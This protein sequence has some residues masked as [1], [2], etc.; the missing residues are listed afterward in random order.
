MITRLLILYFFA[1]LAALNAQEYEIKSLT[2]NNNGGSNSIKNKIIFDEDEVPWYN[3]NNGMVK[4]FESSHLFYPFMDG[5]DVVSVQ[6]TNDILLDSKGQIW[7]TTEEGVFRSDTSKENFQKLHWPVLANI[8][9][10]TALMAEDCYGNIWM[11]ISKTQ[12]LKIISDTEFKIFETAEVA[13][14]DQDN[15]L[16]V[17]N[18]YHCDTVILQRGL[19][20]FV[21]TKNTQASKVPVQY[22]LRISNSKTDFEVLENEW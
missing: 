6:K 2:I 7:A 9:Q 15:H 4:E 13:A 10:Y 18:V 8:N 16:H 3:T 1:C 14:E 12:V 20:C 17:V 21:I 11:A 19:N 5:K 22:K